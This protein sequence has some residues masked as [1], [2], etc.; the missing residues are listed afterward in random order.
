MRKLLFAVML[1]AA[2]VPALADS[3]VNASL[4]DLRLEVIDLRPADGSYVH[5]D[6][7]PY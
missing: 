6:G 4:T 1:A 7:R 3:A 5:K 2:T